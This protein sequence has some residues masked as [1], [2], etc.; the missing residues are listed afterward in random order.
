[1]VDDPHQWGRTLHKAAGGFG[2][3][4][5]LTVEEGWQAMRQAHP[6][7]THRSPTDDAGHG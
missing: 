5:P 3:A 6:V 1:M 4:A 7:N 2:G